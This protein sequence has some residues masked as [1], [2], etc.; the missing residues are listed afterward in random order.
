MSE[1]RITRSRVR[2]SIPPSAMTSSKAK[3]PNTSTSSGSVTARVDWWPGNSSSWFAW[4][5]ALM[6]IG[7]LLSE[8]AGDVGDVALLEGAHLVVGEV[9]RQ[10]GDGVGQVVR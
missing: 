1:A 2:V 4:A 9:E 6:A 3:L 7:V 8:A 10:G 5:V